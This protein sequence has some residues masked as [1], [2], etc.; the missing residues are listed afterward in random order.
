MLGP[1]LLAA[2]VLVSAVAAQ[3]D[4]KGSQPPA[5]GS[6]APDEIRQ[7]RDRATE[8]MGKGRLPDAL[9]LL[10]RASALAV[11]R[12]DLEAQ[13][14]IELQRSTAYRG[15]ADLPKARA[16]AERARRLA[17]RADRPAVAVQALFRSPSA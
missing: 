11:R 4:P 5:G 7:L 14:R 17:V 1:G 6:T 9:S 8:A 2:V 10:D 16:S 12:H 15:L 3:P 13:A